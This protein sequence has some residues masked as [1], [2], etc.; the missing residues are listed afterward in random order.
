[1]LSGSLMCCRF[2]QIGYLA[3]WGHKP[4]TFPVDTIVN[5]CIKRRVPF[6]MVAGEMKEQVDKKGVVVL[7]SGVGVFT[8]AAMKPAIQFVSRTLVFHG[9]K[10]VIDEMVKK[11]AIYE[12]MK[13]MTLKKNNSKALTALQVEN[14]RARVD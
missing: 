4:W 6:A 2:V 3:E 1:M 14:Y 8:L 7:Y 9:S 12:P 13:T 5:R 10:R 11:Q